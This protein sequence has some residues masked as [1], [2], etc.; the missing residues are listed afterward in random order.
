[1]FISQNLC[2]ALLVSAAFGAFYANTNV[3]LANDTVSLEMEGRLAP[4]CAVLDWPS[5]IDFGD[6]AA[7]SELEMAF[8]L[9]CNQPY[10][11]TVHSKNGAMVH[12]ERTDLPPDSDVVTSLPYLARLD[13]PFS[14]SEGPAGS[15]IIEQASDVLTGAGYTQSSGDAISANV[16]TKATIKWSEDVAQRLLSGRYRDTLTVTI[17]PLP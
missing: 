6:L 3:A 16:K 2:S 5:K 17:T 9:D 11:L 12:G 13:I 10:L 4:R 8:G 7:Q 14:R 1:M 15:M